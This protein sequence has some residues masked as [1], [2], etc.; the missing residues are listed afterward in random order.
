MGESGRTRR[1]KLVPDRGMGSQGGERELPS[2]FL[3]GML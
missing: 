2:I 3:K 1:L